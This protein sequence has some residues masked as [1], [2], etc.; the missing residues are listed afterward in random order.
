M[1]NYFPKKKTKTLEFCMLS[2]N[3]KDYYVVS[4]GKT[5]IPGVDD[6]EE[7]ELTD[8]CRS[9]SLVTSSGYFSFIIFIDKHFY[10][11]M[12][13]KFVTNNLSKSFCGHKY[14]LLNFAEHKHMYIKNS[15]TSKT[16]YICNLFKQN[17]IKNYVF[18]VQNSWTHT[19]KTVLIFENIPKYP[20]TQNIVCFQ[21]TSWITW[22][23]H[24]ERPQFLESMTE[25]S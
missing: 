19:Q 9:P 7:C 8:V 1:K 18:M 3:V 15:K 12:K 16:E 21:T 4:Q 23:S 25:R 13:S 22:L 24:K 11:K 6:A 10:G 14:F 5:S 17:W 2:D 20:P